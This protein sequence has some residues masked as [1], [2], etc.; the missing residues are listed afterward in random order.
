M[1]SENSSYLY[2]PTWWIFAW[3]Q[4]YRSMGQLWA[5]TGTCTRSF[6][7]YLTLLKE[8]QR[9]TTQFTCKIDNIETYKTIIDDPLKSKNASLFLSEKFRA[10]AAVKI[11]N[12]KFFH[13]N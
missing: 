8:K 3:T 9:D 4:R 5:Y 1:W 12:F 10:P 2:K 6:K 13:K 7:T 11:K